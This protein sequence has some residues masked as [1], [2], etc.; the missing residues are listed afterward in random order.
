M[1]KFIC[2]IIA[3]A[4]TVSMFSVF[5]S[6]AEGEAE[7]GQNVFSDDV[8]ATSAI[9]IEAETGTVLLE[10]NA[11]EQLPPASVTKVMTLLLVMEAIDEGKFALTDQISVSS[12]AASMGGSQV[13]LK[14][15]ESMSVE[16][17][18]KCTVISSANDAAVALAEAVSGSESAFIEAM[19]QR[20]DELGLSCNFENVTGL[21]D[22]TVNHTMSA[23]DIAVIS[24]ELISHEKILDYSSIWMDTIRDGAFTLTNTNRLVRFYNG[25]NGLKTGSTSKAKFCVSATAK[26][27]GMQLICVIM[28]AP[29]RDV[30]NETAKTLLDW[31][32]A[33]YGLY[34]AEET[35]L[36][37]ADVLGGV[38][39]KTAL[40]SSEFSK[41]LPKGD[42]KKVELL[43]EIP[44]SIAAPV[45]NGDVVGCVKYMLN[46]EEIGKSDI[47]VREDIEKISYV[48][49]F[50]RMI[51]EML[52]IRSEE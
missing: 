17:L 39:D 15:G 47:F 28:G 50:L 45:K 46:G 7:E 41:V 42:V 10:K 27:D 25:C 38:K 31:G 21:D 32:F 2:M 43:Y 3:L 30:R 34:T 33:Q 14:E 13:Y 36:E 16:D 52:G 29:T 37:Y 11:D 9:L 22:D 44:E 24:A 8:D 35:E 6:Y 51:K 4:V 23:R 20:A 48:E 18:L 49:I 1:K 40:Y 19:N 12:Y 5:L 26:R